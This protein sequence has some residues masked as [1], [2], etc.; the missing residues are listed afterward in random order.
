MNVLDLA[1]PLLLDTPAEQAKRAG[2]T[3]LTKIARVG[4]AFAG[5]SRSVYE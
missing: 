1:Q 5:S 4:L 3:R 2:V